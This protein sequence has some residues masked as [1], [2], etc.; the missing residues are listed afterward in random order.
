MRNSNTNTI[1]R[2]LNL[3]NRLILR[4][5]TAIKE[6]QY[7]RPLNSVRVKGADPHAVKNLHIPFNPAK[8]NY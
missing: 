1:N 5:I 4:N 8:L 7:S 6:S 2:P 3:R